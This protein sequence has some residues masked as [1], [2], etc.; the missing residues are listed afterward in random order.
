MR[1]L[2]MEPGDIDDY[3]FKPYYCQNPY[4]EI[5]KKGDKYIVSGNYL[6]SAMLLNKKS[7]NKK[8]LKSIHIL[9]DSNSFSVAD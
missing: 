3:D 7:F 8:L 1:I 2:F 4:I 5:I 9:L 6:K